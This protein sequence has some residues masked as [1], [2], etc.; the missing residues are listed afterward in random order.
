MPRPRSIAP[1][2]WG[3]GLVVSSVVSCVV[4]CVVALS[5]RAARADGAFP[6]SYQLIA[7]A[8]QPGK[9]V[10]GT[11][12]GLFLSDDDGATWT[13]TWTCEQLQTMNA[14][15]YNIGPG[16]LDRVL[17]I[18]DMGFAYSDDGSCTWKTAT[19]P[20]TS[21]VAR[22]YFPDPTN[23][24][25]VLVLAS[26]VLGTPGEVLPSSDGGGTFGT[27]L[28]TAPA[29]GTLTSIEIARSDPQTVYVAMNTATT[30]GTTTTIHPSLVRTTDGGTTWTTI[31]ADASL[32]AS[33]FFIIAV[34]PVD[35][36]VLTVRVLEPA[37]DAVAVSRDGGMTFTRTL[38]VAGGT[39][40]A[41]AR[42]D[43]GTELLGGVVGTV[44]V[45]YQSTDVGTTW[46]PWTP[47]PTMH[48]RALAARGGK[49]YAAA[50]NYSDTFAVGVST[51]GGATF[52]KLLLY[53]EVKSIQA[54]AQTACLE[55][56]QHQAG[57]AV[58]SSA[59]CGASTTP[60]PTKTPAKS[61]CAIAGAGD[62]AVG[63]GALVSLVGLVAWRRAR[64]RRARR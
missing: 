38:G 60:P 32:G 57:L 30:V 58:W 20:V 9:L 52:Q 56:C 3:A 55:S 27:P 43:S 39:L 59:I 4:S 25:R 48:L 21:L 15:F 62:S 26:P 12:F 13:W 7:P 49:L 61:G 50:K 34:D 54:C 10:L 17:A 16:P 23:A 18:S 33:S 29:T 28:F 24:M 5:P 45:E 19:G 53:D 1:L 36:R 46:T 37:G 41:Y 2:V 42:L 6:E 63:A 31:A 11:N 35:A 40:S 8:D 47:T 64:G 22:D 51:D 14:S 44:G